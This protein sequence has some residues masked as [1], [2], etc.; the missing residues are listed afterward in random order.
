MQ[1]TEASAQDAKARLAQRQPRRSSKDVPPPTAATAPSVLKP[2]SSQP[3]THQDPESPKPAAAIAPSPQQRR[4]APPNASTAAES[5]RQI[6]DVASAAPTSE[7]DGDASQAAATMDIDSKLQGDESQQTGK[8]ETAE[9]V[10]E[11]ECS[12]SPTTT[13]ISPRCDVVP[14]LSPVVSTCTLELSLCA[15][16]Q[17]LAC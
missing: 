17:T 2:S 1:L 7:A 9:A 8:D 4:Q 3:L 11:P 16:C 5:E 12:D 13:G 14:D 10:H 6:P 15:Y